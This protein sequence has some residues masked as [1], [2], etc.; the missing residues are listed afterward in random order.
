MTVM[1]WLVVTGPSC[2]QDGAMIMVGRAAA[3]RH[4]RGDVPCVWLAASA[5]GRCRPPPPALWVVRLG[6]GHVACCSRRSPWL[7]RGDEEAAAASS[8]LDLEGHDQ[9]TGCA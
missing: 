8:P 5:W 9:K 1:C 7:E 2:G 3:R 6:S 4:G